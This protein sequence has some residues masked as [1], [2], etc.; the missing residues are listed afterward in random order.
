[1]RRWPKPA[2]GPWHKRNTPCG[3]RP[4]AS[5]CSRAEGRELAGLLVL[6]IVWQRLGSRNDPCDIRILTGMAVELDPRLVAL[7]PLRRLFPGAFLPGDLF[8][9]LRERRSSFAAHDGSRSVTA[10]RPN[11]VRNASAY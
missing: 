5:R 11:G 10:P 4:K 8:L 1:M 7:D 3:S 6:Q 9:A 2:D